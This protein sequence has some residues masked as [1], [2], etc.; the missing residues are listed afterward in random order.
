MRCIF[1]FEELNETTKPEHILPNSLGGRAKTTTAIC[2]ICNNLFGSTIDVELFKQIKNLRSLLNLPSG[3]NKMP[4]NFE[5]TIEGNKKM[6]IRPN[7]DVT[8]YQK[9]FT[10]NKLDNGS[11]NIMITANNIEHLNKIIPNIAATIGISE[12]SLREQLLRA[13]A[14]EISQ[15]APAITAQMSFG[16]QDALRSIVKSC[17]VLWSARTR[18]PESYGSSFD[19]VRTFVK[20]GGLVFLHSRIKMDGRHIPKIEILTEHF[21]P[22]FNLIYVE[23]NDKGRINAYFGLYNTVYWR[24]V[25]AEDGGAPGCSIGLVSNPLK[26]S[27]WSYIPEFDFNIPFTWLETPA[28]DETSRNPQEPLAVAFERHGKLQRDNHVSKMLHDVFR[29]CGISEGDRITEEAIAKFA[30]RVAT[31][32]TRTKSNRVLSEADLREMLF[33]PVDY[34]SREG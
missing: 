5:A 25:L 31:W 7:G 10:I 30:M 20:N 6:L 4:Q 3:D 14:Q 19:Q 13:D 21:G 17:V 23:S 18:D 22:V 34:S 8:F 32:V 24:I 15:P 27:E 33:G 2:S 29:E 12:E 26:P 11:F 28:I 1:C 16:G 9:P